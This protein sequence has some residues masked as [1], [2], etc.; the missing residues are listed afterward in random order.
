MAESKSLFFILFIHICVS[1]SAN[2]NMTFRKYQVNNGLSENSVQCILQDQQGFMWFGTKDG[3]NKFNGYE[4]K[5]FRNIPDIPHSIGNNFIRS[6]FQDKDGNIW[7]GTDQSIFIFDTLT[8]T[9]SHFNPT[10]GNGVSISSAVTSIIAEDNTTIWIGTMTQGAFVYNLENGQLKQYVKGNNK[11]SLHSNLVWRIYKDASNT[12]WIG[13]RN[14]LSRYYKETNTFITY[15]SRTTKEYIDDPEILSI[16]EDSD[17]DIWLGTW[18]GGLIKYNKTT[19][20]FTHYFG[21]SSETYITHIRAIF[22]YKKN[23][24]LVGSDDGLY[25][26][27]KITHKYQR[28]DDQQDPNS[29]SDQNVYAIY[30]DR[31]SG[32]WIG[33]YFGGVNYLSANSSIIEY[34]YPSYKGTSMSGKAVSQFCE[35]KNGNL[36]IATEDGGLNYFNTQ[37]KSFKTYLSRD[38]NDF[39]SYHNLHALTFFRDELWIGTFSRGLDVL[40]INKQTV[41]NYQ[42]SPTDFN[43]IDDNCVFALLKSSK[44]E[45][46]VGT[47]FGLSKYN[48]NTNNFERIDEIRSFVYDIIEDY[49]GHL[50]VGCYGDGVYRYN[51]Q[52]QQWTHF[53]HEQNNAHSICHNKI[54]AIYEDEK[55]RLW[56]GSEGGGLSKYNYDSQDFSTINTSNGLPNDVVYGILDDKYGHIWVSTNKGISCI[57]P[58]TLEI[59]TLTQEDGLQSNQFNYRSSF[60]AADGKL[61]FGGINGFN[62]FYPDQIQNNSYVPPVHITDF[63]L[64]EVDQPLEVDS[65][66]N[67]DLNIRKKIVLNHNQASFRISFVSLSFQ[68]Q[69]KNQYA[70]FMESLNT[71]W[72]E[73]DNQRQVSYI[74]LAPGEYTFRVK[75]SNNNEMWNPQ[76]D[77]LS[78]VILPPWWK[79]NTAYLLYFVLI[80][81]AS[82]AIFRYYLN[83]VRL[84][85]RIKL[86]EFQNEK[87][88]EIYTSKINFFTNIAHEIRT[89]VSLIRAPLDSILATGD[90]NTETHENLSVI[91]KNT[92][93]LINLVNQLLDF[94]KIEKDNYTIAISKI[95]LNQLIADTCYRFKPAAKKQAIQL[96]CN[97]PD[98]H[99]FIDADKDSITKVIS[100]LITNALKFT[101]SIIRIE[102]ER[103]REQ[104]MVQIKVTDD[105]PGIE[106]QYQTKVFEPFFQIEK[107]INDDQKYGTGIGLALSKQ[108]I[109]RHKGHIFIDSNANTGCTFVVELNTHLDVPETP[110]DEATSIQ[111][112]DEP[113]AQEETIFTPSQTKQTIL[114]VEDNKDL[115]N[116]LQNNLSKEYKVLTAL[117]GRIA[118]EVINSNTI[119]LI[120]SDIVMPEVGGMEL[121]KTIRSNQQYSHIPIIILSA[122]TSVESKVGGLDIGAES[123]IEKP[124]SIDYLKAQ[125]K[126]LLANRARL[127]EKFAQSPFISFG[128]IATTK[129][130]EEFI[131]KLNHELEQHLTDTEYNVESIASALSMSRSNLQR[132]IKGLSD[133]T[134]NDYIRIYRLKKAAK[135]IING[136]YRINEVCYLVGFNS[137]SYFAKCFKKQFGALPKDF[138]KNKTSSL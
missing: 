102:A 52:N 39:L 27:N 31:E 35:D 59:N 53:M 56:F 58:N 14:G 60:K 20:T 84:R 48:D 91:N 118:L 3:L 77:Y 106:E 113:V 120:V 18:S 131:E 104:N 87:E 1:V 86:E 62:A 127:I 4:F 54:I 21:Q 43:T 24:L 47:P 94:R 82:Y 10:T 76:E 38:K 134:P 26:F 85:Q 7:V 125:I 121:V 12:I 72:I 97:M 73:N 112:A 75:G 44:N 16:S 96:I 122:R 15:G 23:E 63:E 114:V 109:E 126:S 105:G 5:T 79:T 34:Y 115:L 129:K 90:G 83:I 130:D 123:Y 108:L 32:I 37:K 57:D 133:M 22:E 61:Y 92:E 98:E 8:E 49:Q 45:L 93:R 89:P 78:I 19:N 124:F 111:A 71:R 69:S 65:S 30:Q 50:W 116:F 40:N 2:T 88:K 42:F 138:I 13:T 6:L 67:A 101:Q 9:F 41:E 74:N 128:S 51:P 100:N 55:H 68:A 17:G 107:D 119:D 135:L 117:N 136:E 46:Y 36:W 33:T 132:K 70:Y 29:V 66:F 28:L 81:L 25:L 99:I 137:P 64:L 80:I 11:Q 103:N 110:A 95:N